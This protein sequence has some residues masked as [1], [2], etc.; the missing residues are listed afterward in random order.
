[1]APT[2]RGDAP[3]D[4]A[5]RLGRA[6]RRRRRPPWLRGVS[7]EGGHGGHRQ[8]VHDLAGVRGARQ[9]A[10]VGPVR[11]RV[12]ADPEVGGAIRRE[13]VHHHDA[14]RGPRLPA[15]PKAVRL[16][17]VRCDVPTQ[18]GGDSIMMIVYLAGPITGKTYAGATDWRHDFGLILPKIIKLSPMRGKDYLKELVDDVMPNAVNGSNPRQLMS[19]PRAVFS[20]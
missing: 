18:E 12:A 10:A 14:P 6:E 9:G 19:T 11:P 20:R 4:R 2:R 7:G 3:T 5:G 8:H 17:G 15:G 13:A 16:H 1:M